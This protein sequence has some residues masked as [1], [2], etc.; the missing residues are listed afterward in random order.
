MTPL[1]FPF[2][3]HKRGSASMSHG[4][5]QTGSDPYDIDP[6]LV[7][8]QY[9]VEWTALRASY[10]EVKVQLK[11]A[12][13]ELSQL[14]RLLQTGKL[15]EEEHMKRYRET[16]QKS[17]EIV[18][19]KREVEARLDE[20]QK[21]IRAADRRLKLKEEEEARRDR[22]EQERANAMVEWMGLKQGFDLIMQRRTE[23]NQDMDRL[24]TRRRAKK[25]TEEQYR[26]E[27]LQQLRQLTELRSIETDVKKRLG[28]LLEMI[29][30]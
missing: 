4:E 19:V 10:E 21:E 1:V 15:S 20:I 27:R 25:V 3:H 26:A 16:W 9:S 7:L 17:T 24:E 12:Q 11:E 30:G 6:K 2:D 13:D 8:A 23:I 28:E 18:Q 29:R 22:L 14:D 5:R